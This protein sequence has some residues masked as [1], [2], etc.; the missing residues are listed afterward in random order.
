M[1]VDG[2]VCL[3]LG[4]GRTVVVMDARAGVGSI[5]ASGA[6]WRASSFL[7]TDMHTVSATFRR[8]QHLGAV[9]V[10][11]VGRG[12]NNVSGGRDGAAN[13][14]CRNPQERGDRTG[15]L[16]GCFRMGFLRTESVRHALRMMK[17]CGGRSLCYA[18]A[19]AA[20]AGNRS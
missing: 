17:V 12:R 4:R 19:A 14:G 15:H 11:V 1:R 8:S 2:L 3:W 18:A 5:I 16:Y 20:A 7:W 13:S 9:V 6:A 10:C